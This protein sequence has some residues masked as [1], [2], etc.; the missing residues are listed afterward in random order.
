MAGTETMQILEEL[1]FMK[2]KIVELDE[3]FHSF[4]EQWDDAQVLP[5]ERERIKKDIADIKAGKTTNFVSLH[6]VK[7]HLGL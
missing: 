5:Q 3:E 6:K 2:E 4:K 7:K 1:R